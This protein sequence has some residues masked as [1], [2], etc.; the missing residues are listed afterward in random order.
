MDDSIRKLGSKVAVKDEGV[1]LTANVK[2]LNIVGAGISAVLG[3]NGLVTIDVPGGSGVSVLDDLSDVVISVPGTGQFLRYDGADW[4]NAAIAAGD[5]PAGIDAAKIA[6]GSVSNAEFQRLDGVTS[7]IQTQINAKEP[8]IAAGTALQYWRGDKSW[9]TLDTAA[10]PENGNLYFTNA[11][12]DAR[13]TAQ[14]GLANGLATLDAGGQIPT[15][16][17]PALAITDT[18]VVATQA[19][20]LALTAE[21]GDV[22]IRTDQNK[23]YILQ[24]A[25]PTV[26]GHW[27]ELLTPTDNVLSVNG[28]TGTVV[29]TT[30]DIAEGTNK[31]YTDERVDDRVAALLVAGTNITL[32]YD[33]VANTLTVAAAG[34][35]T[36]TDENAQDAIG[37][38]I[39]GSL[40]YVDA[41]PLLQRAALTGDVTAAAGN[42]ATTIAAGAVTLAKMADMATGSLLGRSTAGTGSPEVLSAATARSLLSLVI[43]TNVQAWSAVLDN[44]AATTG[45]NALFRSAAGSVYTRALTGTANQV[46]ITNGSGGSGNPTFATPQD[47][48]TA[49]TP[50]FG[51]IGMGAAA[52]ATALF[53]GS[54]AAGQQILKS[55]QGAGEVSGVNLIDLAATWNNVANTPTAIK[56]NITDTTSAV[57]SLLMDLQVGASSKF[58]VQKDGT[59]TLATALPIAS[60]GTAAT[61][62]SAARTSLGLAIGTNVQAWAA[63]LDTFAG[64]TPP[65]GAVVGTTDTQTLSAKTLTTPTIADFTNATHGHTNA[66]GGGTLAASAIASGLLATARG[67][68]NLDVSGIAKGGLVV[69]SAAGTFAIKTVGTD[70]QVL[71]AD[72]ASAGGMK[73]AAAPTPTGIGWQL[74]SYSSATSAASITVSGLGLAAAGRYRVVVQM[75][76]KGNLSHAFQV[77]INGI[78]TTTYRRSR[79]YMGFDGSTTFMNASGV[80]GSTSDNWTL[81]DGNLG[82]VMAEIDFAYLSY[83]GTSSKVGMMGH[84]T[85]WSNTNTWQQIF[86]GIETSQTDMTSITFTTQLSGSYSTADFKVWVY[87]YL[88]A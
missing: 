59:V 43:G 50:Q 44:M 54:L 52:D 60:G 10:V 51:R 12:A 26:V 47:I 33:D 67:G 62:A 69:G 88:T 80:G 18:F 15:S 83:D 34:G 84:A 75:S 5:L 46:I 8:T 6:D 3:A 71:T 53:Y 77:Q 11:R 13:I 38:M 30:T 24:V 85:S 64:K 86:S 48:A 58:K 21:V 61:S 22:A 28:Q 25:D 32:T 76:T 68:F 4:V 66:A 14:K 49:S 87:K 35:A 20:M 42:N 29:L 81:D 41:T 36:Y 2:T 63:N 37:A 19:A 7:A 72:S 9:Q 17:L 55:A 31:Y 65:T 57:A 70:A 73:W 39:D 45:T 27:K 78:T 56:L 79:Y 74:V 16:Q 23:S 1:L 40:V 82:A